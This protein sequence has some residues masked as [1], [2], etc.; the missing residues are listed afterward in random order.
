MFRRHR[1]VADVVTI[2]V[3]LVRAAGEP[4]SAIARLQCAPNRRSD[5]AGLA[6]HVEWFA[7]LVFNDVDQAGIAAQA[8][9][10]LGGEGGAIFVLTATC[11]TI[12]QRLRIHVN[13][14]LISVSR[15]ERLGAM[16]EEALRNARQCVRSPRAPAARAES[17]SRFSRRDSRFR[18]A[19]WRAAVPLSPHTPPE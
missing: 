16:G 3:M 2:H 11:A 15:R 10:S 19:R 18:G 13:D 14:G 6:T 1:P 17:R 7:V 4:A 9:R 8:A 12:P 5:R